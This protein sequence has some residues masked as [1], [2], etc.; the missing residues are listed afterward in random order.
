MSR[1]IT[2]TLS[3]KAEEHFNKIMY[4]L[5]TP[6]GAC[7]QSQA[8]SHCLEILELF[9]EDKDEDLLGYMVDRPNEFKEAY[10]Y[11]KEKLKAINNQ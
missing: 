3:D 1:K 2:I 10:K 4:E 11:C 6:K 5:E 8:I 9:E 7:N